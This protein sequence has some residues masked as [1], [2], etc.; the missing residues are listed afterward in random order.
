M[1]RIKQFHEAINREMVMTLATAAGTSVT[2]RTVSPVEYGGKV[3]FFTGA[4]SHKYRQLRENPNCCMSVGSFFAE[5]TAAFCGRT[6]L[7]ENEALRKAYC[8]KFP[9]AFDEGLAFGGRDAEF[10][11]LTPTRL[12]GWAFEND[13]PTV[14][15]IPT[16]PFALELN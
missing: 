10:I 4:D 16:V 3:L 7:P 5:A 12:T 14:D 13:Q 2:M 9:G 6:M 15:G 8:D 1:D 11:L